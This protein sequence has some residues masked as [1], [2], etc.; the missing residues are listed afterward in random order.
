MRKFANGAGE[1]GNEER[2]SKKQ[3]SPGTN[4]HF[5]L[6]DG[7]FNTACERAET[8]PTARQAS[9]WRRKMG[10]AWQFGRLPVSL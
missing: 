6:H 3:G 10:K 7:P 9:K 1:Q 4:A 2:E 5:A 8:A